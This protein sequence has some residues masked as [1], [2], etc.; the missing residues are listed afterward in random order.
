M[1]IV[2]IEQGGVVDT[3]HNGVKDRMEWRD[4]TGR[5]GRCCAMLP[6]FFLGLRLGGNAPNIAT[7]CLRHYLK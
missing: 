3:E 1:Y 2:G 7:Q 6:P 5:G 4:R